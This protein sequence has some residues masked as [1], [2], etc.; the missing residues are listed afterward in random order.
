MTSDA[1]LV[2]EHL[3]QGGLAG[4]IESQEQDLG[5]LLPQPQRREHAIEPVDEKHGGSLLLS[6]GSDRIEIESGDSIRSRIAG[7]GRGKERGRGRSKREKER[8]VEGNE[9]WWALM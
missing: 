9:R 4:I 2:L 5:L 7:G 1:Y 8:G 3:E 6:S